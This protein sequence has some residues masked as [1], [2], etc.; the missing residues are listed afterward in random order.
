ME[1]PPNGGLSKFDCR[2]QLGSSES[3]LASSLATACQI[4]DEAEAARKERERRRKRRCRHTSQRDTVVWIGRAGE[5]YVYVVRASRVG[6]GKRNVIFGRSGDIRS[7]AGEILHRQVVMC[8]SGTQIVRLPSTNGKREFVPIT[9]LEIIADGW[10]VDGKRVHTQRCGWCDRNRLRDVGTR[11]RAADNQGR[12]T[13]TINGIH[14]SCPQLG[15]TSQ[16]LQTVTFTRRLSIQR[17]I[18][19]L[20]CGRRERWIV[21]KYRHQMG[22]RFERHDVRAGTTARLCSPVP[23]RGDRTRLAAQ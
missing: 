23:R 3:Q 15:A 2:R 6:D 18:Y 4:T 11:H 8:I 7:R 20:L 14:C 12:R 16:Q 10:P 5:L 13:E 17:T 1:R 22:L 19:T 9:R 21:S